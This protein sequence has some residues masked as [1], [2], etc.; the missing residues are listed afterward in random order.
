MPQN[1]DLPHVV[2]DKSYLTYKNQ[3][4]GFAAPKKHLAHLKKIDRWLSCEAT[5][6]RAFTAAVSVKL[7]TQK[8]TTLSGADILALPYPEDGDLD[9]SENEKILAKDIVDYQRDLIRL[10]RRL[11]SN[12]EGGLT[13]HRSVLGR[14]RC[15]D[16]YYLQ[17]AGTARTTVSFVAG[18]ALPPVCLWR[19]RRR[20]DG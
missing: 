19:W 13:M 17:E 2:W 3:I 4:V 5:A 18:R 10:G 8:A 7:F 9:L 16:Q 14:V 12:V 11:Y 20:L 1:R 6:L 15:S